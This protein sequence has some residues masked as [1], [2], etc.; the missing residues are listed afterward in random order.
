MKQRFLQDT[1][2][3]MFLNKQDILALKVSSGR[4]KLDTYFPD[5]IDYKATSTVEHV[6]PAFCCCISESQ[7]KK[8]RRKESAFPALDIFESRELFKAKCYIRDRFQSKSVTKKN[9]S[10]F[11]RRCYP[12]YTCAIDTENVR[13]VF[14]STKDIIQRMHLDKLG[15]VRY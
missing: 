6:E 15:V 13:H 10:S 7:K 14:D 5:Y 2:V 1:S 12:H 3:I 9:E 11:V 8:Q 4:T